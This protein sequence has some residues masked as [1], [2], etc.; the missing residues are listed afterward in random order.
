MRGC[1][2]LFVVFGAR[3]PDRPARRG[4]FERALWK[5][6]MV[7]CGE[8]AIRARWPATGPRPAWWSSAGTTPPAGT[9]AGSRRARA[10]RARRAPSGEAGDAAARALRATRRAWTGRT[11]CARRRTSARAS[12]SSAG[13]V[14]GTTRP[15]RFGRGGRRAIPGRPVARRARAAREDARDLR[16]P[17]CATARR[18][19]R[20]RTS[21]EAR[22]ASRPGWTTRRRT[23][24]CGAR[25]AEEARDEATGGS[26]AT[27]RDVL[28][29][30]GRP[31]DRP[32]RDARGRMRGK[33]RL[34]LLGERRAPPRRTPSVSCAASWATTRAIAPTTTART[35][36]IAATVAVTVQ[37]SSTKGKRR[38]SRRRR[39]SRPPSR[40]EGRKSLPTT[41]RMTTIYTDCTT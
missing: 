28:A 34:L 41:A 31:A 14:R 35:I 40:H 38:A 20:I 30:L 12:A 6:R 3:R 1:G 8:R 36:F 5:R 2:S 13:R 15:A 19:S 9:R 25:T 27:T 29:P 22:R 33:T 32:E 7:R 18:T 17:S 23:R 39:P 16:W 4:S 37:G 11:T 21:P 24:T 26:G 10:G